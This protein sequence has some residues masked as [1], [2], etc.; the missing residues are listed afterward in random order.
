MSDS[1]ISEFEEIDPNEFDTISDVSDEMDPEF[2]DETEEIDSSESMEDSEADELPL[3]SS[4]YRDSSA[5][6]LALYSESEVLAYGSHPPQPPD[7]TKRVSRNWLTTYE[8]VRLIGIRTAELNGGAASVLQGVENLETTQIAHLEIKHRR[9]PL[10]ICRHLPGDIKEYW[11]LSELENYV[12]DTVVDR[13]Y[14]VPEEQ[15]AAIMSRN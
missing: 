6:D 12:S 13:V 2:D 3:L 14:F 9:A 5:C 1:E 8:M 7:G 4:S 10:M 15:E 11:K